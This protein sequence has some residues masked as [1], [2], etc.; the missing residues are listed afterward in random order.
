MQIATTAPPYLAN[1]IMSAPR[2]AKVMIIFMERRE[3]RATRCFIAASPRSLS[4]SAVIEPFQRRRR[5]RSNNEFVKHARAPPSKLA[6]PVLSVFTFI[7]PPHTHFWHMQWRE[8]YTRWR[9]QL[10]ERKRNFLIFRVK[11]S[12][13]AASHAHV[14]KSR[15]KTTTEKVYN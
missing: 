9:C 7:P 11:L 8:E 6:S 12:S 4:I 3:T 1:R 14:H 5:R 2:Q 10:I 15:S 13:P